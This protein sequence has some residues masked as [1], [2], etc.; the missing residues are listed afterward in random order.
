MVTIVFNALV[1]AID[2]A[3]VWG[4]RGAPTLRGLRWLVGGLIVTLVLAALL[5]EDPF[6]SA[7]LAAYAVFVHAPVVLLTVALAT[8]SAGLAV[9]SAAF[10]SALAL[11][12]VGV[13]AFFVEPRALEVTHI[14]LTLA[15][16]TR[17]VRIVLVADLQFDEFGDYER[18][19]LRRTVDARPDLVVFAGDYIQ[20]HDGA[21]RRRLQAV[22]RAYL[23]EI[24]F[25]P[26][27]GAVA[28]SG[29]V[30]PEGWPSMFRELP[31]VTLPDGGEVTFGDVHVTALSLLGSFERDT[32]IAPHAGLHVVVGHAPDYAL[33]DVDADLLLAGHTHGGQVRLPFVGPLVTLSHVPDAWAAGATRLA[34]G[35]W[36]VVSRGVGMERGY[37]PRLRFLCRPELVV[38]DVAPR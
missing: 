4:V 1:A 27:I 17:P 18:A 38:I 26:R 5:G 19:V 12:A 29:N 24:R 13:D 15:H 25:A 32:R 11:A 14:R 21:R 3:V 2:L 31:V 6:G 22:F 8:Q 37:A 28:V 16:A 10:V 33:G 7:R 36:L 20:T 35:R 30:D 34:R 9:R 23:R